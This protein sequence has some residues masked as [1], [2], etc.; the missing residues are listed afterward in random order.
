MELVN[1]YY[2]N[3]F[4]IKE[5]AEKEAA[6]KQFME[7]EGQKG[8]ANIEKLISLYGSNG[9]A[10]GSNLTWADILIFDVAA[11]LFNK[12]PQF[13]SDFPLIAAVHHSV[14]QHEKIAEYVK[15]RPVT[16]F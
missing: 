8:A 4:S 6:F 7:T 16:P 2:K 11:A 5:A 14:S 10:V 15:N 9:H 13:A 3:V 1:S 12:H